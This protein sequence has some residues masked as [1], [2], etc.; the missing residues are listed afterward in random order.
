MSSLMLEVLLLIA[1]YLIGAIPFGYLIGRLHGV[2]LFEVGSGNIGATNAARVLGWPLGALVFILDFLKGALPVAGIVPLA[3]FLRAGSEFVV[4]QTSVLQVSAAALSFLGHLYPVYLGFRGGKGVATGAGT[5]VVLVPVP[6]VVA[7]LTWALILLVFRMV[8]LASLTSVSVLL[9]VRL[10]ST[11]NPFA[12][13]SLPVT[14][15]LLLGASFVF[16]KHCANLK[17]I[18]SGTERRIGDFHMRETYIRCIHLLALGLWFGGATFFNFIAAVTIFD[19]FKQVVNTGP[20][21]R[22]AF[23]T[24]IP[25]DAS[26]DRKDALANALAGSAVGPIFPRYFAMA[27]ICGSLALVTALSWWRT[28]LLGRIRVVVIAAALM[29]VA[30]GWPISNYVSELRMERFSLN[31]ETAARAKAAFGTWHFISLLLSFLMVCLTALGLALAAR[32]P[33]GQTPASAEKV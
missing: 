29:T 22:T 18:L 17:R 31:S 20:S 9:L 8:S 23:E 5:I 21:D 33:I 7:V 25:H 28:D 4:G 27:T 16:L 32:L 30:I 19:S 6:A 3:Q 24:I 13:D 10:I 11:P 14:A 12:Y 1:S 26:Q 15:Y 2:N